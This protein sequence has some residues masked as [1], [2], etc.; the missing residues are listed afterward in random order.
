M[1][2]RIPKLDSGDIIDEAK[3]CLN[4]IVLEAEEKE[5]KEALLKIKIDNSY[6]AN[7]KALMSLDVKIVH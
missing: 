6:E 1:W 3:I 2:K 7:I 5:V 4:E